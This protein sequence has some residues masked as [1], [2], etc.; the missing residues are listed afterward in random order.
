MVETKGRSV[1]AGPAEVSCRAA[2]GAERHADAREPCPRDGQHDQRG[3]VEA[4]VVTDVLEPEA[5]AEALA[6]VALEFARWPPSWSRCVRLDR[7][8]RD[9]ALGIRDLL[10]LAPRH[11]VV[12]RREIQRARALVAW[13][14]GTRW[15]G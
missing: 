10:G 9:V 12:G 1:H 6:A 8:R 7:Q 3:A 4:Q 14:P 15:S 11:V 13:T 2:S 5:L